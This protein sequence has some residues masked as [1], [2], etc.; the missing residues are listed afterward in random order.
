[1]TPERVLEIIYGLSCFNHQTPEQKQTL[2]QN[3]CFGSD[4]QRPALKVFGALI[5][6]KLEH[7]ISE[8]LD[9][10]LT[11]GCLPLKAN[12]GDDDY[13][14]HCEC[15][16]KSHTA[17]INMNDYLSTEREDFLRWICRL[18][19]PYVIYHPERHSHYV[20][21]PGNCIPIKLSD[22]TKG[23]S[24]KH[25]NSHAQNNPGSQGVDP[26]KGGYGGFSD[27]HKVQLHDCH[28]SLPDTGLKNPEGYYALKKLISHDRDN[29]QL[30]L[31]SL[32]FSADRNKDKRHMIQVLATFEEL[33]SVQS[34]FYLLFDWAE[35]DL[36]DF[37]RR[38][39]SLVGDMSH[40]LA[41]SEQFLGL[42][43]TLEAIHSD[44]LKFPLP[45]DIVDPRN[46]YGRHGDIKP[47]NILY[48][49]LSTGEQRLVLADFGLGR[50]HTK[51]SIS[52]Q[53][54]KVL[55]RTETYRSPEFDLPDGLVGPRADVYSLGCVFLEHITWFLLGVGFPDKFSDDRSMKDIHGFDADTFFMLTDD[56]KAAVF[57]PA[58]TEWIATL[59]ENEACSWFLFQMLELIEDQMLAC[60]KERRIRT[61]PLVTN[62]KALHKACQ[63]SKTFYMKRWKDCECTASPE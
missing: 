13:K 31:D 52:K 30:E 56:W 42:G 5:M 25:K 8:H 29:F 54:P 44:R 45:D 48:F 4:G 49:H 40:C 14:L 41:M 17:I 6:S 22:T 26:E 58:V 61:I 18:T 3:I 36:Q 59:K 55:G 27:V 20:L 38:N 39:K 57:K 23:T 37:W 2:A 32:L 19:A 24:T 21:D 35:G 63:S 34:T 12:S 7:N 53:D 10:G 28:C 1:M 11:D 47:D 15:S 9:S 46:L 43:Q 62:L 51:L 50:L 16:N 60:D 33:D